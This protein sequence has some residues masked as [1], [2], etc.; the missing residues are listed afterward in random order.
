MLEE[1]KR[2]VE[3]AFYI[4]GCVFTQENNKSCTISQSLSRSPRSP[5]SKEKK[6][7][8]KYKKFN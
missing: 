6:I 8:I 1:V 4:S 2:D 5:C 3:E 7:K